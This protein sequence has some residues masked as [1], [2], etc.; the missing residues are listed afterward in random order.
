MRQNAVLCI[1]NTYSILQFSVPHLSRKLGAFLRLLL[2]LLSAAWTFPRFLNHLVTTREQVPYKHSL[3]H[4]LVRKPQVK[5]TLLKKSLIAQIMLRHAYFAGVS[6]YYGN[7]WSFF[8]MLFLLT[9]AMQCFF[10]SFFF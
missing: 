1:Y 2:L 10:C 8:Y 3:E 9:H 6:L 4:T 7:L 5:R